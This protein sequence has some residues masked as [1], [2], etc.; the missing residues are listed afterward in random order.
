MLLVNCKV[1]FGCTRIVLHPCFLPLLHL[2]SP[3]P[4]PEAPRRKKLDLTD[5]KVN[6]LYEEASTATE[7]PK[8]LREGSISPQ[9]I[10]LRPSSILEIQRHLTPQIAKRQPRIEEP[11]NSAAAEIGNW[12][13]IHKYMYV[14]VCV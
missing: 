7:S 6:L 10:N 2:Q 5:I 1:K 12:W 4:E 3:C 14:H 8:R 9:P 11:P 13:A